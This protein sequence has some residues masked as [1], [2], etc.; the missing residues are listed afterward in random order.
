MPEFGERWAE[1]A[2]GG[3]LR[4]DSA[5]QLCPAAGRL[6]R[7]G[8]ELVDEHALRGEGALAPRARGEV[9]LDKRAVGSVELSRRIPGKK[10]FSLIMGIVA[11]G[12][13]LK[14]VEHRA[15]H[16]LL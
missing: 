9:H 13:V 4:R 3:L 1:L 14:P 7:Q 16:C 6:G 10:L 8:L 12:Q 15:R 5:A 2:A 11:H